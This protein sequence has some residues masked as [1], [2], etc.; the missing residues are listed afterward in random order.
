M[1]Q[2]KVILAERQL[3]S[4]LANLEPFAETLLGCS[5]RLLRKDAPFELVPPGRSQP[6]AGKQR[7]RSLPQ[8]QRKENKKV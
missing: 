3:I 7:R 8:F 2:W 6:L 4:Y 5:G 1:P